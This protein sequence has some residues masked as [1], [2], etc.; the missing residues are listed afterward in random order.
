MLSVGEKRACAGDV[1]FGTESVDL[2][3]HFVAIL[4]NGKEA[5][6]MDGRCGR[7]EPGN[8]GTEVVPSEINA[9]GDKEKSHER[10][11]EAGEEANGGRGWSGVGHVSRRIGI[12]SGEGLRGK[13][14]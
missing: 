12:V 3:F 9:I 6:T 10:G 4:G 7:T 5:D 8:G 11:K 1:L 14:K 13:A 2:E